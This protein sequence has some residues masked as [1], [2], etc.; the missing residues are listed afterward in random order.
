MNLVALAMKLRALRTQRGMTLEELSAR[1][2]LTGSMLCKIENFRVTP[3]LPALGA[4][5]RALGVTLA[6]LFEGLD[7]PAGLEIVRAGARKRMKRDDSPWTYLALLSNR[8]EYAV[9]PFI[10]EI[11]AGRQR[12][13]THTHEGD[14]F[15]LMLDGVL[16]FVHGEKTHRLRKGDSTY[17]NGNVR[18]TLINPTKKPARILVVYCHG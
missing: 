5:A 2:G 1:S 8:A 14:E 7:E 11:P 17:S 10:V 16:D 12:T 13:E 9:E 15:M 18:H 6:T 3:S 4:I